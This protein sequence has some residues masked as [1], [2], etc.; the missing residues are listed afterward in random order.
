MCISALYTEYIREEPITSSPVSTV[1]T[2]N[3][4][5]L[6]TEMFSG[7]SPTISP[8]DTLSGDILTLAIGVSVSVST[9][10]V[11]ILLVIIAVSFVIHKTMRNR[12]TASEQKLESDIT[13]QP[14]PIYGEIEKQQMENDYEELDR[15][16][17][18]LHHDSR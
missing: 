11:V 3:V 4:N 17:T 16:Q 7:F 8:I 6:Q 10:V 12:T 14:N 15:Y 18:I 9:T 5:K 2:T 1:M 13:M